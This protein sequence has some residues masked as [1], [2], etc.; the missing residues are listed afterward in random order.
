VC[1]TGS[2]VGFEAEGKRVAE[3]ERRSVPFL[4]AYILAPFSTDQPK[5][6]AAQY[7]Y[8]GAKGAKQCA[9]SELLFQP[10]YS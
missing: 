10:S 4:A 9:N 8:W 7:L 5:I 3:T 2:A 1:F 6:S